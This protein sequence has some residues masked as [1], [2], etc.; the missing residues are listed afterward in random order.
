MTTILK[1]DYGLDEYTV[2][3]VLTHT[4][5][6]EVDSCKRCKTQADT[7]KSVFWFWLNCATIRI[8]I[9]ESSLKGRV[10]ALEFEWNNDTVVTHANMKKIRTTQS[11]EPL[12]FGC[13]TTGKTAVPFLLI[14]YADVFHNADANLQ[15]KD[16]SVLTLRWEGVLMMTESKFWKLENNKC[17]VDSET[18]QERPGEITILKYITSLIKGE[19]EGKTVL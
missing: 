5:P 4:D 3:C 16:K 19:Q 13:D 7:I 1:N 15:A 11:P 17:R 10:R 6:S 14:R 2:K 8:A 12:I 9:N 18:T